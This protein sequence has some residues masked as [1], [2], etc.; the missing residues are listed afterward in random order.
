MKHPLDQPPQ[1]DHFPLA[2]LLALAMT[3]FTAILTETLPAGLLP[4]ISQDLAI[5]EAY[6]GQMITLFALG[7]L[8]SVIPLVALTQNWNRKSVLMLAIAGFLI[9]NTITALSQHY[10]IILA[11]RLFGGMSAGLCWGL[12]AGYARRLVH[13]ALQG[14]ALAIAMFGTPVALSIGLPL[15]TWLGS[16]LGWRT[17]F[18]LVSLLG[19]LLL[20][21]VWR[22]VPGRASEPSVQRLSLTQV[23]TLPGIRPILAVI[24]IWML[25]HNLLYTYIAPFLVHSGLAERID[26]V[27]LVFG[28]TAL[29][30]IIL[31]GFWVD[32]LLRSLTL[33]SLIF[34]A[35]TAT[36]LG[37]WSHHPGVVFTAVGLW[38]LSFG[39]AAT[40]LVTASA[41]A[42]HEAVDA[43]QSIVVTTW[44]LAIASGSLVGGL[45]LGI[46]PVAQFP[47]PLLVLALVALSIAW[48]ART[49]SFKPGHR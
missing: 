30:S 17:I 34:F 26:V 41:D 9:F 4:Q 18:L 6:A 38:G 7:A 39:G 25:G 1:R 48:I 27:L 11:A 22:G 19:V 33:L 44:N 13:P 28:L 37:I 12:L 32:R 20:I 2:S 40:L 36:L 8:I 21:W 45:L 49:H 47:W 14:K 42:A 15:G 3:G 35:L 46:M 23:F 29:A 16:L 24:F 43:A 31:V 10:G 5:S